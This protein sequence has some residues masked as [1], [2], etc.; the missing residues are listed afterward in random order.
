MGKCFSEGMG[1]AE[2]AAREEL[3]QMDVGHGQQSAN[4]QGTHGPREP[5]MAAISQPPIVVRHL[6]V[7]QRLAAS[8]LPLLPS[9][10]SGMPII[11][12]Q[13]HQT[14]NLFMLAGPARPGRNS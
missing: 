7:V 3:K 2:G 6:V 14:L 1:G 11:L 4:R 8:S 9:S 10:Q 5:C 12:M 13:S